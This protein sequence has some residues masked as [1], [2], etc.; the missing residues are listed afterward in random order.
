MKPEAPSLK[1]VVE[2]VRNHPLTLLLAA[3]L[4]TAW[5]ITHLQI[6]LELKVAATI[7]LVL[8]IVAWKPA[9]T[10]VAWLQTHF[11]T[12]LLVLKAET[13]NP[14]EVW[15]L[16]PRETAELDVT[17]GELETYPGTEGPIM[18]AR[19][20]DPV[21][22]EA[23]GTWKG[24]LGDL[25]LLRAYDRIEELRNDLE[26]KAR[27]G[28]QLRNKLPIVVRSQIARELQALMTD[29]EKSGLTYTENGTEN[30]LTDTLQD[31]EKYENRTHPEEEGETHLFRGD[32]E[33][34]KPAQ[35]NPTKRDAENPD[36]DEEQPDE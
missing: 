9:N 12:T 30:V 16:T 5:A 14:P 13:E 7:A 31:Y 11:S 6:P 19:E 1:T 10:L 3:A 28:L 32:E 34:E 17:N 2:T 4:P 35:N 20:F 36:P 24:T 27:M 8:P 25:E 18:V 21:T 23:T 26:T 29:L 22:L 33:P 15:R